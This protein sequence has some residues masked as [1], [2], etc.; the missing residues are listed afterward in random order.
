MQTFLPEPSFEHSAA[1][2][3]YRRLGKQRVEV[4][5]LLLALSFNVGP[6]KARS[7]SW[8]NHPAAKMWRG[9]ETALCEYGITI[10]EEWRSRGYQDTLLDQFLNVPSAELKMPPWL[11]DPAFHVSHQSNL[12]R[13]DP[14]YYSHYWPTVPPT[15]E[16][17]WPV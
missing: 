6:H 14:G 11:G 17:V 4:K 12:I 16:Y 1:A 9:Y 2:L 13:K 10:C 7:S 3:D 8:A 5:Q 15:L